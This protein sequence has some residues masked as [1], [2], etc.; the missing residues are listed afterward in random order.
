MAVTTFSG[1]P[2]TFSALRELP[3]FAVNNRKNPRKVRE[4]Y[5]FDMEEHFSLKI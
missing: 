3:Q 1:T 4:R 2:G 5:R